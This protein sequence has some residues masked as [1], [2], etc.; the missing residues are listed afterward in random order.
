MAVSKVPDFEL[1][2]ELPA[3]IVY[4]EFPGPFQHHIVV[5]K[6][7][8]VVLSSDIENRTPYIEIE[9]RDGDH[10][11]EVGLPVDIIDLPTVRK[12]IIM[13][14]NYKRLMIGRHEFG[15]NY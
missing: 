5:W 13:I 2:S 15:S 10:L 12:A 4:L 6:A 9:L 1:K 3:K 8:F 14:R 11:I 7:C